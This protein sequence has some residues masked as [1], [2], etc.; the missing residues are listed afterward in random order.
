M[1]VRSVYLDYNATTPVH[2]EVVDAMLP[3]LRERFGNPSSIHGFGQDAKQAL[4]DSRKT[5]A[6]ALGAR[7]D[8]IVFTSG[9]TE[10]DNIAVTGV[11]SAQCKKGLHIITSKIE[12]HAVLAACENLASIGFEISE[13]P[14]DSGGMVDPGDIKRAIRNDTI[15]ITIMHVNN[16]IGTILPIEEIGEIARERGVI[17]HTDAVQSIGKVPL[18]LKGMSVDLLSMSGHKIYGPKGVGLLYVKRGTAL[19]PLV[20]GGGHERNRRAGTENLAGIVGLAKAV[21][22]VTRDIEGHNGRMSALRD[23]LEK[24]LASSVSHIQVNGDVS[25]RVSSTSNISFEFVEGESLLLSL[26][27]EGIAVSSGSAC[28]S[29]SMDPSHVLLAMGVSPEIAQGSLR[30]SLGRDT[31]DEDIDYVLE[32]LPRIVERMRSMSPLFKGGGARAEGS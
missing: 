31:K 6:A 22:L 13:V 25:R 4:E 3:F 1:T 17:F 11:A 18:D 7:P 12:H 30:I 23:K 8:E 14:C 5:V 10:A 19:K 26:D 15:L 2:P 9:A 29:G 28:S 24:G 27:M 21:E 32:V 16:E 20:F